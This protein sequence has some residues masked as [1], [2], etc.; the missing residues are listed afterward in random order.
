MKSQLV[1]AA[2]LA[3]LGAVTNGQTTCPSNKHTVTSLPGWGVSPALFPC[4]YAGT[5]EAARKPNVNHNL[6]YWLFKNTT[7]TPS[8][9]LIIWI[10]GETGW[11]A[12]QG[13][14]VQHGPL[15]VS[16]T[17]KNNNTYFSVI[18]SDDGTNLGEIADILYLDQPV[19]TGFSFG[20]NDTDLLTSMSDISREFVNF[21]DSFMSMYP[22]Y[23][24]PRDIILM[25]EST[26]GKFLPVLTKGL[27]DYINYQG[28]KISIKAI[29]IGNPFESGVY[30][31]LFSYITARTLDIIDD[32]NMG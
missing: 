25:G 7:L 28:G 32:S 30:Q 16:Q 22:E 14:F 5:I 1:L 6:F 12:T 23:K 18:P 24:A 8:A 3:T 29:M 27:D 11:S 9:P 15:T 4:M 21:I 31:R 19:G 26:A 10:L 17:T 20:A 2:A 13:L